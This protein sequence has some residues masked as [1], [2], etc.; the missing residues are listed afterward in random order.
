MIFLFFN[1]YISV[2]KGEPFFRRFGEMAA[3]SMGVAAVSFGIGVL[4]KAILG[5]DVG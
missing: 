3:I 2:A 4:A 5:V 1:Y